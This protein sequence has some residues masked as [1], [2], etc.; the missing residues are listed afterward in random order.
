[1]KRS[2]RRRVKLSI[3]GTAPDRE[4]EEEGDDGD[5]PRRES[6]RE[7]DEKKPEKKKGL[8]WRCGPK[9]LYLDPSVLLSLSNLPTNLQAPAYVHFF[10]Q[11]FHLHG[12]GLRLRGILVTHPSWKK[13]LWFV[14]DRLH[15]IL[16]KSYL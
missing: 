14:E 6:K 11:I 1:M 12:F 10:P 2:K 16:R 15:S 5:M 7:R 8:M 13:G 4:D 3:G 9:C